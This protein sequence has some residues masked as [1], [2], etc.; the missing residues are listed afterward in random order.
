M[1][2]NEII[3]EAKSCK[4]KEELKELA[5]KNNIELSEEEINLCFNK[6]KEV[7]D[8]ELDNVG[9]GIS[10]DQSDDTPKYKVG[11]IVNYDPS[12]HH[13]RIEWVSPTKGTFEYNKI[14]DR[15]AFYYTI[16]QVTDYGSWYDNANEFIPEY[17]LSEVK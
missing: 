12:G 6:S 15:E 3:K 14:W 5:S 13:A 17:K 7:S 8:D 9:G 4:T 2:K 11:D 1:N 10:C 16:R